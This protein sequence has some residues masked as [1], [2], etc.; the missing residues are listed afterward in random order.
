[1]TTKAAAPLFLPP[2]DSPHHDLVASR[3]M[4]LAS[5]GFRHFF[6]SIPQP[7]ALLSTGFQLILGNRSLL[8][9]LNIASDKEMLGAI[10]G[11]LTPRPG[12]PDR[13]AS[14]QYLEIHGKGFFLLS[15]VRD[16]G[17]LVNLPFVGP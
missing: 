11:D 10:P 13:V 4:L 2:V 8:D 5:P 17:D 1:M 7:T 3:E 6:E 14:T 9:L 12:Q 16:S 15:L